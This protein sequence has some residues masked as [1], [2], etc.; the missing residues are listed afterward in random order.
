MNDS[1]ADRAPRK[2]A[3][4]KRYLPLALTVSIGV[5]MSFLLF[6]LMRNWE[7]RRI[8]VDFHEAS[9][10]RSSIIGHNVRTRLNSVHA[11]GALYDASE[12]VSREEFRIFVASNVM[13]ES[14]AE[15]LQWVPRVMA[16]D[17]EEFEA[18][19][20]RE[21]M[22]DFQIVEWSGQGNIVPAA[23]R[24]QYFPIHFSRNL[25]G[26]HRAHRDRQGFDLASDPI[27][28]ESLRRA[29]DS[30]RLTATGRIPLA[31]QTPERF[32]IAGVLPIYRRDL[33]SDTVTSRRENLT[34]F[35]VGVF[36]MINIVKSGLVPM[37]P[38]GVDVTILDESA[39][40]GQR[41]LCHYSS[42][43]AGDA[44]PRHDANPKPEWTHVAELDVAGRR[45]SSQCTPVPMFLAARRTWRSWEMLASGLILTQLLAALVFV[46][47]GRK[48]RIEELI[49]QRTS[50][51]RQSE[52]RF[53]KMTGATQDAIVMMD[54]QGR[55]SFWNEAAARIF[56]Y[57]HQEAL[58]RDLHALLA[59]ARY[60]G[61]QREH[62]PEFVRT[63]M[64]P[65]MG[66]VLELHG[67]N[68]SGEELPVEMSLSSVMLN[69]EWHAIAVIRDITER[70]RIEQELLG[71]SAALESANKS[72]AASNE[73]AEAATEAKSQFLANMSHEIR[74][75]LT[76]IL[77]F[78]DVLLDSVD[79]QQDIEAANTIKRNSQNLLGII[80]DILDLSK[81]E[82]HKLEMEFI[83]C[84]PTGIV[85]D[86]A[87]LM[88]VRSDAKHLPLEVDFRG[89][90]PAAIRSDPTRLRQ[91]LVNLLGNAIKFTETGSIR[92]TTRLVQQAGEPPRLMFSVI[93]TG[94]GMTE[95]EIGRL[96]QPFVQGDMSTSREYGGS[97]L[98]LAISKRL[99]AALGGDITVT[100]IRGKGSTFC[101]TVDTGPL[102]GVP[103]L[104]SP[105]EAAPKPGKGPE[106]S[107]GPLPKLDC[108]VLLAEDGVDNQRLISLVL[109]KAGAQ[110]VVV[111]NGKMACDEA[112]AGLSHEEHVPSDRPEA[113]DVILMDMQMPV[114]NGY[115]AARYLRKAGYAGPIIALTANA[116]KDDRQKC[117]DAGCDDYVV[118]P[119]DRS[120]LLERVSYHASREFSL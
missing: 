96:F 98:G 72:L 109:R 48:E 90:I 75:P 2:S 76:A 58:G 64:G 70:K 114:M 81:I 43:L 54:S 44:P 16:A 116:M 74:T 31:G 6:G 46:G 11:L 62:F 5:A 61:A 80:N 12:E 42:R 27:Y 100:S 118:K 21:G 3:W 105:A 99:A 49:Q 84:A 71:Y 59:P 26:P 87:S 20:R 95:Q 69:N 15:V 101:A 85:A 65:A 38:R 40:Q 28:T 66:K 82:A 79:K 91:I 47:T 55:I 78:A 41:F 29:C 24:K 4:P 25:S 10:D 35:V 60:H 39:A 68:K 107:A 86:V 18:A 67:I 97:G 45:W 56:G 23:R 119:I 88:R 33:P 53:R 92:L 57:S 77:G 113:F 9:A 8:E 36:R 94:R 52:E 115:E 110:V 50:Q 7:T 22:A 32:G 51:L 19:A 17:R 120:K 89:P 34:G 93:D 112:L 63:G 117:L 37:D 108:H 14:G 102:D 106:R 111:D 83:D 73:A 104:D 103:M 1:L 13:N 30:G